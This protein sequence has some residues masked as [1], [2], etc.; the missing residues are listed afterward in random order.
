MIEVKSNVSV[1]SDTLSKTLSATH[2]YG[3]QGKQYLCDTSRQDN[4]EKIVP[5]VN[6]N[7]DADA[8]AIALLF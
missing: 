8:I 1:T 2:S 4:F 3:L 6:V 5:K 7:A